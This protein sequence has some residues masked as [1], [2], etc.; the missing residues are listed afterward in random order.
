MKKY[1]GAAIVCFIGAIGATL[2]NI[3]IWFYIY[4]FVIGEVTALVT[5]YFSDK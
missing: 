1:I 2:L 5:D 3:P 4:G